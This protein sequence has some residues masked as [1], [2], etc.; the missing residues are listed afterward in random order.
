L[1]QPP[2]VPEPKPTITVARG[3]P[4]GVP[5]PTT[6]QPVTLPP[7][8]T[9]STAAAAANLGSGGGPW[10]SIAPPQVSTDF[11][12]PPNNYGFNS[13]VV[14]PTNPSVLF[15]GTN[16]QGLWRSTDQG[17]TWAKI[18]TGVGGSLLDQGRL[19]TLAVDPLN[20]NTMWT[21]AGYGP[22]GP[23]KSTDGGV[24][25]T[26]MPAGSPTQYNDVY[27]IA[28]DPFTPNH[29]IV[30]WHSPWTTGDS[31]V[32]EST[33]GGATWINHQPP[34]GSGWGAGNAAWFLT[35]SKTWLVGSQS[36]GIWRTT[37]SGATWTQ[38]L[39]KAITHGA[40]NSLTSVSG[41]FYLADGTSVAASTDGGATWSDIT[42]GLPYAYYET[43]V[44]DGTNLYT[45]PSFPEQSYINGPWYSR[46]LAGGTWKAYNAQTTCYNGQ[47]NGP[48]MGAYD[49]VN[50]IAYSV[51]W[52]GGV[53]RRS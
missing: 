53:W 43:V 40:I 16:Y 4:P 39:T 46:P 36:A 45:A 11:N 15:V 2:G 29:V 50:H 12:N 5:C 18:N 20:H 31:G 26:L 35:N 42:S 21:S 47:C 3:Q 7:Q 33:D 10:V 44:T 8:P 52:L 24:S 27:S 14:D 17:A 48:V 38:V 49:A 1:E 37:D 9:R 34:A 30:A 25:W 51:N 22:G 19:W 32:S 6:T 41:T 28:L 23:L 13:I